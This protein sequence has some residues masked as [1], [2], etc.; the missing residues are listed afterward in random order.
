MMFSSDEKAVRLAEG[1]DRDLLVRAERWIVSAPHFRGCKANKALASPSECSCG[2]TALVL[3]FID[4]R[5][6][7]R[8]P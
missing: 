4:A 2:R 7:G 5:A 6:A 1:K 3:A 8:L